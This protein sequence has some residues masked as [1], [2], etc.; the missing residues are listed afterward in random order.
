[1][2]TDER[3]LRQNSTLELICPLLQVSSIIQTNS[4]HLGQLQSWKSKFTKARPYSDIFWEDHV[5]E[6]LTVQLWIVKV[7]ESCHV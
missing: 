3:K 1:M 4:N 5:F 7:A 2:E 6:S